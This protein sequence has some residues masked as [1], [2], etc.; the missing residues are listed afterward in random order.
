MSEQ[1]K[2]K[3]HNR[4]TDRRH[5]YIQLVLVILILSGAYFLSR[6]L[7]SLDH[8][9]TP[10]AI[11]QQ[12]TLL[13]QAVAVA[14]QSYR[15]RFNATGTVQVRAVTDIVPQ[16]SGRVVSIDDSAFPGGQFNSETVLFR[17]EEADYRNELDRLQAE[18]ARAQTQLRL[19]R[20][21]SDSA[22]AEW[23]QLNPGIPVP[24]LV[25]EIPQLEEARANLQAARAGLQNARLNLAR[26]RYQLPFEGRVTEFELEKGQYAVAG[27]SY[28]KAYRL[29]S[30]EVDVPLPK[31]QLKWLLEAKE[32][33]PQIHVF[34]DL[35]E[36]NGYI[37]YVKRIAAK[38]DTQTRFARVVLG[39]Q[40]TPPDLVPG[41]FV[42]VRFI[43]PE[44]KNVWVLPLEALQAENRIWIIDEENLLQPLEPEILQITEEHVVARSNGTR[45]RVVCGNLP[46]ATV[47]TQVQIKQEEVPEGKN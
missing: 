45:I 4:S 13:V 26:T 39:L 36:E 38:L 35:G 27:Q 29:A 6:Y 30:L 19:Q 24:P 41:V 3:G 15:L 37:A 46:E 34:S 42:R 31:Q 44:R 20:A 22:E 14:P 17:I 25:A 28:G 23:H 1:D 9:P 18:V 2:S 10:G 21:G 5:G 33:Q 11:D 40:E 47:G 7:S 16:V 43:G 32:P 8:T 12:R